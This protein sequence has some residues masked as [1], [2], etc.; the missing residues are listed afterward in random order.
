[1]AYKSK[2]PSMRQGGTFMSKHR[3]TNQKGLQ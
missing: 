1:M 2:G 3:H